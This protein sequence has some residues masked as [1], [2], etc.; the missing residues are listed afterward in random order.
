VSEFAAH[1]IT[2]NLFVARTASLARP[3]D[4]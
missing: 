2:S 1:L 3:T 4:G